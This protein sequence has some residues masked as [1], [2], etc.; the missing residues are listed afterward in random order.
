MSCPHRVTSGQANSSHKLRYTVVFCTHFK[1]L[2]IFI[3]LSVESI[4]KTNHFAN[5]KR[6][7]YIYNHQ[8]HISEELVPSILPLLKEHIRLGHAGIV[9]HSDYR[10]QIFFK[11]RKKKEKERE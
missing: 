10:Y 7:T 2:L 4:H 11:R 1:T 5:I 6:T 8:T 9:D 3:N